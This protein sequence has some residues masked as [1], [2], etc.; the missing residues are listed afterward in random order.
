MSFCNAEEK[1]Y[2]KDIQKL[3][4][5]QIPIISEH[6]FIDDGIEDA[7]I[8]KSPSKN[9]RKKIKHNSNTQKEV[10]P[11]NIQQSRRPSS[12]KRRY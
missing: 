11:N 1:A 4:N 8:P 9:Q 7:A 6:P 12:K 10:A 5:Q 2:L 3:I